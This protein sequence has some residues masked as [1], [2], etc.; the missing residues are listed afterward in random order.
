MGQ[1]RSPS[2]LHRR[3]SKGLPSVPSRSRRRDALTRRD[4]GSAADPSVP[5]APPV[6]SPSATYSE[7]ARTPWRIRA[8]LR[9][10]FVVWKDGKDI[11]PS[12]GGNRVW[13]GAA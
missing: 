2:D 6:P 5:T 4:R 11:H 3:G 7:P 12:E 10:G 9:D 8:L 1:R 13:L